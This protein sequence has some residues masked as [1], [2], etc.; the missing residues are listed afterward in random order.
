[1]D[2][3]PENIL[4]LPTQDSGFP[5]DTSV[6]PQQLAHLTPEQQS[7][8]KEILAHPTG[9]VIQKKSS[10]GWTIFWLI[11]LTP[12][13]WYFVAKRT[14]W[15]LWVKVT[16]ILVTVAAFIALSIETELIAQQVVSTFSS[17]DSSLLP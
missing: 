10:T 11:A 7:R 2:P 13:G 9:T 16:V 6:T 8:I 12:V 5:T 14:T 4:K 17:V 3:T 1:M 15:P